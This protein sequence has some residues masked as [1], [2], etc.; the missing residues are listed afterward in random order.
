MERQFASTE[1]YALEDNALAVENAISVL[2]ARLAHAPQAV[3]N[4]VIR[5]CDPDT[6][7]ALIDWLAPKRADGWRPVPRRWSPRRNLRVW[8]LYQA[9]DLRCPPTPPQTARNFPDAR[10]A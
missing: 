1:L 6:H 10:A 2:K 7:Q 5:R 9:A 3:V 4:D 8:M